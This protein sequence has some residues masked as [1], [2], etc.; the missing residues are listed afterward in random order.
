VNQ[1]IGGTECVSL[2]FLHDGEESFHFRELA[3]ATGCR[4]REVSSVR[5]ALDLCRSDTEIAAVVCTRSSADRDWADLVGSLRNLP[6]HPE[7]LLLTREGSPEFWADALDS[8]VFEVLSTPLRTDD[9]QRLL[10]T[11]HERWR[12]RR[13]TEAER[14]NAARAF[15]ES[16]DVY[17]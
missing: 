1:P 17:Q 15:A 8:G 11:A 3:E 9:V 5:Q 10:R 7:V 6:D 14:R 4:V 13:E 12:R 16:N 2:L